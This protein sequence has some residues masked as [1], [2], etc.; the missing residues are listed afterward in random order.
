MPV[1]A[2]APDRPGQIVFELNHICMALD[3]KAGESGAT[4]LHRIRKRG[5]QILALVVR[6]RICIPLTNM[7]Q[8]VLELV[9]Q[10]RVIGWSWLLF[11]LVLY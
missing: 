6:A 2:K 8:G 4:L 7:A 3:N 10:H 1:L 9:E 5:D 11:Y